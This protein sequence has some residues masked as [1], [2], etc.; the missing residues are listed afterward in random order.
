M[1]EGRIRRRGF[2][3]SATPALAP[4]EPE[5]SCECSELPTPILG[6]IS[7]SRKWNHKNM[8][9][10]S[11]KE[12]LKSNL[13]P[14]ISVGSNN[15][16]EVTKQL[17]KLENIE[18]FNNLNNLELTQG[19]RSPKEMGLCMQCRGLCWLATGME[20]SWRQ[21]VLFIINSVSSPWNLYRFYHVVAAQSFLVGLRYVYPCLCWVVLFPTFHTG[22]CQLN[23]CEDVITAY[24]I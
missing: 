18:I 3:I 5:L 10:C 22:K 16:C 17:T 24:N 20:A 19:H 7:S 12:Q 14:D 13:L 1:W 21:N 4:Q 2:L 11:L 6:V 9:I 8:S 15:S 23:T